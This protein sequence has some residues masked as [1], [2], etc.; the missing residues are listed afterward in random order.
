MIPGFPLAR[1]CHCRCAA[2]HRSRRYQSARGI[3]ELFN[4][5]GRESQR[6]V[7]GMDGFGCSGGPAEHRTEDRRDRGKCESSFPQRKLRVG[8]EYISHHGGSLIKGC[9]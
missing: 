1:D 9:I 8:F 5:N 7:A 4:G 6:R 3:V 2:E